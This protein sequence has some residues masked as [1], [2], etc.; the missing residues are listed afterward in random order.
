MSNTWTKSADKKGRVTLGEKFANRTVIVTQLSDTEVSVELATV[1]PDRELW[2]H[3]NSAAI[4][5]VQRGTRQASER[6][7]SS[8]PPSLSKD[9]KL[10]K[11]MKDE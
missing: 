2:L 11:R 7:F 3:K 9:A 10:T 6:G 5:S 1:I 8:N 4:A